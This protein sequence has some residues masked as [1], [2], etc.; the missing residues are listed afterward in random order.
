M[1]T[2]T[3]SDSEPRYSGA[4]AC[5]HIAY[6]RERYGS[7]AVDRALGA[8]DDAERAEIE[9]A[10][11]VGWVDVGTF[12][13]FHEALAEAVGR[14]VEETHF[15]IATHGG[16]RTFETLWRLLLRVAG[17]RFVLTRAPVVYAKTYDTGEMTLHDAH[18]R[19]G[20]FELTGWPRVPPFVLRGLRAGM[21]EGLRKTGRKDV[22]I[23]VVRHPDGA[24]FRATW[25]A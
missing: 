20:R 21:S 2:R 3:A 4:L 22:R 18:D 9:E 24:T 10:L 23:E 8:L 7:A 19:G 17:T 13:R 1:T 14:P 25:E 5:N 12:E 16:R 11:A 6:A 15:E